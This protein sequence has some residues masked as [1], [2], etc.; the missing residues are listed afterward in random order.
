[1]FSGGI[2]REARAVMTDFHIMDNGR[3]AGKAIFYSD[4][5]YRMINFT[6]DLEEIRLK[7][8]NGYRVMGRYAERND[9]NACWYRFAQLLFAITARKADMLGNIQRKYREKDL[10]YL[11]NLVE[12]ELPALKADT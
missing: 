9:Q 1:M 12:N 6:C 5:L 8:I 3:S 10:T 2:P 11:I 7:F 4:I